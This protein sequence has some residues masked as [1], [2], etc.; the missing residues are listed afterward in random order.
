[1]MRRG[2]GILIV[3]ALTGVGRADDAT[4]P[5]AL[6]VAKARVIR[7][8]VQRI[9]PS[10]VTVETIGGAQPIA[11]GPEGVR[12]EAFRLAD[13]PTTGMIVSQDGLILT[14]SINFARNPTVITVTLDDGRQFVA[15]L[16]GRDEIRRLALLRI[17][18]TGLKVA[19]WAP[20][21]DIAVGQYA[22]ACG[23][24]LMGDAPFASLGIVSAVGRRNGNAIQT[25][26]KVSPINYG[27]PLIDIDGRVMGICVPMAGSGG[28]LAGA[29]WYDSGIGFAICKE[30]YDFVSDRLAAG[31]LI[32]QGKIG[33]VLEE[34]ES[35]IRDFFERLL[36]KKE[37]AVRIRDVMPGSP[38]TA[39]GL[40]KGDRILALDG[41]PV[42]DVPEMLRRLSDRA[43]GETITLTIKRRWRKFDVTLTL[44]RMEDMGKIRGPENAGSDE[45]ESDD[46]G[47]EPDSETGDSTTQPADE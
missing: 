11:E 30:K 25:D 15:T 34:D 12:E 29:E 35:A 28:A 47:V 16:L 45:G 21:E 18:E 14:S 39:V 10:L 44:A 41:Q 40:R 1:M 13:G 27:G 8:A 32:E 4:D 33:I 37:Q 43:A 38:A 20:G 17:P 22:I 42:G 3:V 24:G 36:P 26:A 31:E 23:R 6:E 9:R 2:I 19:D 5:Y 7:A 46:G